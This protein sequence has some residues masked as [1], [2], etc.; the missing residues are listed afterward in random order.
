MKEQHN[1]SRQDDSNAV[2]EEIKK[3]TASKIKYGLIAIVSL[4]GMFNTSGLLFVVCG[5][6]FMVALL[7]WV[8]VYLPFMP[9][10]PGP[11]D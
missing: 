4:F 7:M 9:P 6:V 2:L 10:D 1:L 8:S 3:E 11:G 5:A